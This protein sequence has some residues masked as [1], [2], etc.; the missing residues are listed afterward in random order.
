MIVGALHAGVL[1]GGRP[2]MLEIDHM[3]TL[4]VSGATMTAPGTPAG[5]VAGFVI[6]AQRGVRE[7]LIGLGVELLEC[8]RPLPVLPGDV[9]DDLLPA[10]GWVGG[11]P[12]Q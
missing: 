6:T 9:G 11:Q 5:P 8:L 3:I 4:A 12:G 1:A 10:F 7:A 2:M